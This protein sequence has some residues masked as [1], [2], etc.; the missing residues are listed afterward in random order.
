MKDKKLL[1]LESELESLCQKISHADKSLFDI[2]IKFGRELERLGIE[3]YES[4]YWVQQNIDA[5]KKNQI[6]VRVAKVEKF[7][8]QLIR[9]SV[10]ELITETGSWT[11]GKAEYFSSTPEQFRDETVKKYQIQVK[12][13]DMESYGG[14]FKVTFEVVGELGKKFKKYN[15]FNEV[16]SFIRN[17]NGEEEQTIYDANEVD[18]Y[19]DNLTV[20]VENS[21]NW[22]I[23]QYDEFFD[24][25]TKPFIFLLMQN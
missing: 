3:K 17:D 9:L 23:E 2:G 7:I 6:D 4:D 1:A 18:R 5:L 19:I 20:Y 15:I 24:D 21:N 13:V 14:E 25:I 8:R 22:N 11:I 16:H 10:K 12:N